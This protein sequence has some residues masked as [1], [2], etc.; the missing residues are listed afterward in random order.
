MRIGIDARE[1]QGRPTG[2]GRYLRNLIRSWPW[3]AGDTLVLF[4]NGPAPSDPCLARPGVEVRAGD[5]PVRSG[6]VWQQAVLPR[7]LRRERLD[8]FFAPAYAAPLAAPVPVA[9]T[10]HDLSFFS[11]PWD[12]APLDALRR[13]V[14]VAASVA[15]STRLLTDSEFGRRELLARFPDVAGR[16]RLVPLGGDDDIPPAA[17]HAAPASGPLLLSVGSIL[18]RRRLPVLLRAVAELAPRLP[19]L[20]LAIV[21]DNRTHPRL[22]L[23]R[24][25]ARSGLAGRVSHDGF[26]A[27][28]ELARLYAAAEACVYLSEYEGFGLPVMEALRRGV[29]T[30]TSRRPATGEIYAGAALLAEPDDPREIAAA[31]ERLLR[32]APLRARLRRAGEALVSRH[33]WA[34]AAAAT[35]AVLA[36]AAA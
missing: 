14:L 36:E 11:V 30:L 5:A 25:V 6:L 18:N 26:L 1:L 23:A 8:V 9:T 24:L 2:A 29:P 15:R 12:F 13:R 31:L 21:G 27:E 3:D 28:S 20:R 4:C 19:G 16:A 7:L 10:V 35:R 32:D 33:G 34:A 17:A 22:D